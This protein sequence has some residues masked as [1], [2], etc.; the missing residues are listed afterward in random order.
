MH[1]CI[2]Q[3]LE[4]DYDSQNDTTK[5]GRP[6]ERRFRGLEVIGQLSSL[7]FPNRNRSRPRILLSVGATCP[8]PTERRPVRSHVSHP[9]ISLYFGY[10][11]DKRRRNNRHQ[12][13]KPRRAQLTH[14]VHLLPP[15]RAVPT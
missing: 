12:D 11:R 7:G 13:N 8:A 4:Y 10:V 9:Q 6:V 15:V 5:E 1:A 2:G 3:D 14:S